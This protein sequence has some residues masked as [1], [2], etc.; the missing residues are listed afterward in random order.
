M[1]KRGDDSMVFRQ[2]PSE[3]VREKSK[4]RGGSP[5]KTD[6]KNIMKLLEDLADGDEE[7]MYQQEFES[8]RE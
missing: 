5:K 6:K 4:S 1:S 7:N 3:L 8:Y 2:T